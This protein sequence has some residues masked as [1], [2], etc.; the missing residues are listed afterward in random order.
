MLCHARKYHI[1]DAFPAVI[2]ILRNCMLRYMRASTEE[3]VFILLA[4]FLLY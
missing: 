1:D 4:S 3:A 2:H